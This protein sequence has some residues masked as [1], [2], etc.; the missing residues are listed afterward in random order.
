MED[1]DSQ[2]NLQNDEQKK[3]TQLEHHGVSF[4]QAYQPLPKSIKLKLKNSGEPLDL[5]EDIEEIVTWWADCE[6]T[7]FGKK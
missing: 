2:K 1:E 6:E 7:E 5:P 4:A 3:W